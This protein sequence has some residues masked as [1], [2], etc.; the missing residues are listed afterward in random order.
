LVAGDE[1]QLRLSQ[2]AIDDVEIG[3]AYAA[4]ADLDQEL[5]GSRFAQRQVT[6]FERPSGG[7][8]HHA[9]CAGR[10]GHRRRPRRVGA[11]KLF[12]TQYTSNAM[13]DW[14]F[15]TLQL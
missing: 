5:A 1:R 2:L 14:D 13:T 11:Q 7:G 6:P 4:G 10:A 9:I 3:A 8:E 12:A 15:K